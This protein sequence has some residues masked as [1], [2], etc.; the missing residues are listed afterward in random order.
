MLLF[1]FFVFIEVLFIDGVNIAIKI[2]FCVGV[3]VVAGVNKN[4]LVY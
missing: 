4:V 2:R 1:L 3:V